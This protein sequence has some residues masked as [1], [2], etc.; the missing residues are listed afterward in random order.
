MTD[1]PDRHGLPDEGPH[2]WG[3]G[4]L[5]RTVERIL[6]RTFA[7]DVWVCGE[8][9]GLD[10]PP[11]SPNRYLRVVDHDPERAAGRSPD[12][13]LHVVLFDSARQLVNR[14][15]R[16][17]GIGRI[18]EG[19]QVRIRGRIAL[20]A[21][22]GRVQLRMTGI[23]PEYTLGALEAARDR[24]LRVLEA[25]GLVGRNRAL[26]FPLLP[27]R[28]GLVTSAGSAAAADFLT[29]LGASGVGF[30]VVQCHTQVQGAMAE[31]GVAGAIATVLRHEVDVVVIVRGGGDRLDLA[32]FDSETIARAV[33]TCP[34]PVWSGIGHE[35]DRSVVDEVAHRSFK[36]PTACAAALVDEVR[37]VEEQLAQRGRRIA[38]LTATA[39][40][41]ATAQLDHRATRVRLAVAHRIALT[42]SELD[43]RAGRVDALDPGRA[44]E[45]GW[46]ILRHR[47]GRLV[48]HTADV[49]AGDAVVV[50]V[51]DGTID[52]AVTGPTV[53][54]R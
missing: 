40:A 10:R 16:K 20:H 35:I 15:L 39:I 48:R 12:A 21:P 11:G 25:E 6:T 1:A 7:G 13:V 43:G 3:V 36:T 28:I 52:A 50:T 32:T 45:R 37:R 27:L 34:V 49:A 26:P 31:R 53:T 54:S 51:S 44:L 5:H 14:Q 33:A 18:S 24:V 30:A 38:T 41:G 17:A 19:M 46:A 4:E 8:I 29:E 9:A 47:D 23:D 2:T 22:T 42:H